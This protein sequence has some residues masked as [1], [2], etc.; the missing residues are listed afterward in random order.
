MV[1]LYYTNTHAEGIDFSLVAF[2]ILT[3]GIL[4]VLLPAHYVLVVRRER[5]SQLGIT[6]RR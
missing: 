1:G 4:N 2:V 3:N 6:R 5:L